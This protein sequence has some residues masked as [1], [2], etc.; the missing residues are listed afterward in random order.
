MR[1]ACEQTLS[2]G[3]PRK[4]WYSKAEWPKLDFTI[5]RLKIL[6][7]VLSYGKITQCL[8]HWGCRL[9]ALS[10]VFLRVTAG[11]CDTL[12]TFRKGSSPSGD[13]A[14]HSLAAES[15]PDLSPSGHSSCFSPHP[16]LTDL[17]SK[18]SLI[19]YTAV[20]SF[21]YWLQGIQVIH[22]SRLYN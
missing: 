12:C 8:F 11:L 5:S 20:W 6:W 22:K 7:S 17:S 16:P 10:W 3:K 18:F 1:T 21:L 13:F 9:L 2:K 19:S 4:R 15:E 14:I